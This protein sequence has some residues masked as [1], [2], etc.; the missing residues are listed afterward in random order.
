MQALK[1][2]QTAT[3]TQNPEYLIEGQTTIMQCDTVQ[4]SKLKATTK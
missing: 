4:K 1:D 3:H 2:M